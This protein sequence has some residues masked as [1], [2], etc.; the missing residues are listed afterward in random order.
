MTDAAEKDIR[1]ALVGVRRAINRLEMVRTS[2]LRKYHERAFT[3]LA[4]GYA[5]KTE[6]ML[7]ALLGAEVRP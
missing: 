5:R 6:R 2:P 7:L 1:S 4:R 3:G